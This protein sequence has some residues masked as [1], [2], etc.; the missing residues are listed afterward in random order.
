[1]VYGLPS[2]VNIS[3]ATQDTNKSYAFM[4]WCLIMHR[5]QFTLPVQFIMIL[6]LRKYDDIPNLY[7]TDI[8]NAYQKKQR[9]NRFLHYSSGFP[10]HYLPNL[11]QNRIKYKNSKFKHNFNLKNTIL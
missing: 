11:W 10:R 9:S 4:V 6:D 1:M 5:N 3:S 8:T 7:I 2:T